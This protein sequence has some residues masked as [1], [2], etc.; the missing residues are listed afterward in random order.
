[1][2]FGYGKLKIYRYKGRK[3]TNEGL[4]EYEW[5]QARIT[6]RKK[7]FSYGGWGEVDIREF[8]GKDVGVLIMRADDEKV[9]KN[10]VAKLITRLERIIRDLEARINDNEE[11]TYEKL[12]LIFELTFNLD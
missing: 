12:S 11:L 2:I 6:L 7:E 5:D 4:K 3:R 9:D 8:D 1:M 10:Y